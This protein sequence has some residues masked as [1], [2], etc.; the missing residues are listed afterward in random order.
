MSMRLFEPHMILMLV[1]RS[2]F[3]VFVITAYLGAPQIVL[4]AAT[5]LAFG[6]LAGF[7]YSW[8]ATIV[9]G[10]VTYWNGRLSSGAVQ[11]HLAGATGGRFTAYIAKNSFSASFLV[12]LVPATPFIVINMGFGAARAPF[13]P[14]LSGLTMGVL[15]KTAL[16]AFASSGV[17]HALAGNILPALLMGGTA[18]TV[19]VF[20][21]VLGRRFT[22]RP[23]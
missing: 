7:W 23:P 16:V 17:M 12:R 3:G 8:I 21:I 20:A 4:I 11:R 6:P 9:S 19:A 13:A 10:A 5:V 22:S 14:F 15:P 18:L 1:C 2:R